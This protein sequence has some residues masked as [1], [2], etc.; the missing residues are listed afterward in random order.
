[1]GRTR[2]LICD[3]SVLGPRNILHLELCIDPTSPALSHVMATFTD[4][5]VSG[6]AAV[7]F[8]DSEMGRKWDS[9]LQ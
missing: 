3:K 7:G 5:Q 8:T 4:C 2:E 1:M 9:S 6:P